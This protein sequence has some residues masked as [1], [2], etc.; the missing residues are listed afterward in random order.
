MALSLP[1]L[2]T[3]T[4]IHDRIVPP[5]GF[6]ARLTI[7][8]AGAMAFL[9]VFAL[10]L[11]LATGRLAERWGGELARSSTVRISAPSDQVAAQTQAALDVLATTPGVQSARALDSEEERALL[12]PW[13]GPSLPIDTLPLPVLIEVIETSD[14]YDAEGLR[15][16]LAGEA[17]GAVL[18]DH[19][20]W[21]KPLVVAANR[22]RFLGVICLILI[23]G[24]TA[25]M[26]TLA[27]N[28]A[29]AANG[30][31]IRVLRLV[32]AKDSYIASAFIRQFTLRGLSG[33]LIGTVMGLIS[34]A[35]LPNTQASGGFLTG[36]GFQGFEWLWPFVIP[37]F[38]AAVSF[39][40]TRFAA[41]RTLK[42]LM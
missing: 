8:T 26:I 40:A 18:D 3:D 7:L 30:Q 9:A 15:L 13:F 39:F 38:A 37:P 34:V 29:L 1:F 2:K 31:V 41:N 20:R 10:T 28:A 25:A 12:E 27:A 36:L 6:T 32:G 35:L 33:A 42:R 17:P 5:S 11:S 14:G 16:R 22:L 21:R 23:T 4:T 19:T 24:V